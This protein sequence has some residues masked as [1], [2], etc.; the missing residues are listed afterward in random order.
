LTTLDEKKPNLLGKYEARDHPGRALSLL[1]PTR[2]T[3]AQTLNSLVGL[4]LSILDNVRVTEDN[5]DRVFDMLGPIAAIPGNE[6]VTRALMK[7]NEDAMWLM[8]Q[9]MND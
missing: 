7:H 4:I 2:T 8:A 3:D 1:E 9:H 6:R 5:I